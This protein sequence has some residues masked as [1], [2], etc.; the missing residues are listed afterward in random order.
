MARLY[1]YTNASQQRAVER[2]F[3]TTR[4]MGLA[5]WIGVN[6]TASPNLYAYC[7]G[8]YVPQ[9]RGWPRQPAAPRCCLWL[10]I[11]TDRLPPRRSRV[12]APM[13]TGAGTSPWPP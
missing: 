11:E 2:Y 7:D 13:R 12:A 10:R 5:Y 1:R 8:D 3:D 6:R 4:A 9:V